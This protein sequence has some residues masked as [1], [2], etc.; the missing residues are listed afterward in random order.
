MTEVCADRVAKTTI[1]VDAC[2]CD[3][4]VRVLAV[5]LDP[6]GRIRGDVLDPP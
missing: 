5:P 3:R 6:A 1:A 2:A 4:E